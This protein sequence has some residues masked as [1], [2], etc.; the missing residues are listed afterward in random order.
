MSNF[1]VYQKKYIYPLWLWYAGGIALLAAVNIV[2]LQIP[3]LAKKVINDLSAR[4]NGNESLE[5]ALA[6]IGLGFLLIVV[7][8]L[9]RVLMFW[10]SRKAEASSKADYFKRV[11]DLPAEFFEKHGMGD[12]ISRLAND[13][14][15]VRIY[16]GFGLL[17]ILN[18]LFLLI[19]T[20][21]QMGSVHP[22]L[23]IYALTPLLLMF[24]ITKTTMGKM[25]QYSKANQ[26]AVGQ[27]T[28]KVTESFVN[29]HVLQ[30]NAAVDTFVDRIE[31]ENE[32]VYAS[33]VKLIFIRTVIFPLMT[34]LAGISQLVILFYGGSEIIAGR[35]TIG[36]ILAFNVYIALLTFPLAALGIFISVHQRAKTALERLNE[37]DQGQPRTFT[38]IGLKDTAQTTT[39]G[40][41]EKLHLS[42]KHLSF[43]F[44]VKDS[45]EKKAVLTEV[46]FEL[47]PGDHIGLYGPIGSGKS[48]LLNLLVRYYE[49]PKQSIFLDG[50]DIVT[51][52]PKFI[53]KK[54]GYAL[55]SVHLFSN[56]VRENMLFG[57]DREVSEDE[58]TQ[59]A[60]AAQ[61]LGEIKSF[62]EGWD[63]Q[64]GEKGIRLS[65]G[66]KQ[67]LALARVFLR[68]P[69]ILLLD[70]VLSAVDHSTEKKILSHIMGLGSSTIISS[71]RGSALKHCKEI[72]IFDLNGRIED[73]G[74]YQDL[75]KRHPSMVAE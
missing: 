61:I 73:R 13:I 4:T 19:F 69:P 37:I 18:V 7:R 50:K 42:V 40:V 12:L 62:S 1:S 15:H 51:L 5:T 52:D 17:Q 55:Q 71:H 56:T 33:N 34:C 21:Y 59:A 74:T 26:T 32:E 70:D 11:T 38:D 66:Q 25:H 10:P 9:S 47:Q 57:L 48:S 16:Y 14:G 8:A 65:G 29:V 39:P 67:R 31:T 49:P 22:T 3:Q 35:L 24:V 45:D 6:I 2:N 36:D 53:R 27:L 58:I 23:T 64:I 28:N 60:E 63:T 68:K 30:A 43:H 46:S 20:I 44:P 75:I 54:I 72:L 41:L